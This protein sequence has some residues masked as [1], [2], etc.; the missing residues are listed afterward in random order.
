M[1]LIIDTSRC[2]ARTPINGCGG[3][4]RPLSIECREFNSSA[5]GRTIVDR[6]R[7]LILRHETVNR[8][9]INAA[10]TR[11]FDRKNALAASISFWFF[12][13][14]NCCNR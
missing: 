12:S 11:L 2:A 6:R 14:A 7:L 8:P 3:R 1:E 10:Q 5:I 13:E 4:E 9:H